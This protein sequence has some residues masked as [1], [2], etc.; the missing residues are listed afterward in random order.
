MTT[1]RARGAA[2]LAVVALWAP[3]AWAQDGDDLDDILG[4]DTNPSSSS[5]TEVAEERKELEREADTGRSSLEEVALPEPK[6]EIIKPL[7][8]KF[9]LKIGRAELTPYV[10]YVVNDPFIHR[11]LFG[12]NLGYHITEV[13]EI[14]LQGSIAPNFG[15]GDF[16]PVTTQI[17]ADDSNQVAPEISRQVAHGM[18]NFVYSPLFGKIATRRSSIFFDLYGTF[19]TG[20]VYTEDDLELIGTAGDPEAEQTRSQIHPAFGAG[21]G[22]RVAFNK[23]FALRFE[24]RSISY[25]GVLEST[26][27]ELR[28]NLTLMLG[29][30]FFLGRRIE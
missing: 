23:T 8:K 7:Q 19:G 14:E 17:T 21:G 10:G 29:L 25:I 9:F 2:L 22:L 20:F 18:V 3:T 6:D 30:S 26:N 12:L 16:K 28:N 15:T 5:D 4:E 24:V 13:F 27:L 11:V 1:L